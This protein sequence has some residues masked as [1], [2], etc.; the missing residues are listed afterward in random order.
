[1]PSARMAPR[2]TIV[3]LEIRILGPLTRLLEPFVRPRFERQVTADLERLRV[4]CESEAAAATTPVTRSPRRET[5]SGR[6]TATA[7]GRV[8]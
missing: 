3:D 4:M 8:G 1:M 5:G 2:P 7:V 6:R